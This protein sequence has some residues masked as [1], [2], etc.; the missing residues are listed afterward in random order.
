MRRIFKSPQISQHAL[1]TSSSSEV[2]QDFRTF[3][4]SELNVQQGQMHICY[5]CEAG[6]L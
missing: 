3:P 2:F 1:Y 5:R 6:L 4:S